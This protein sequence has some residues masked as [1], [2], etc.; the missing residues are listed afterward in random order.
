MTIIDKIFAEENRI[1]VLSIVIVLAITVRIAFGVYYGSQ[2]NFLHENDHWTWDNLA[3]NISKGNGYIINNVHPDKREVYSKEEIQKILQDEYFFSIVK[4]GKPTS[5]WEP[6]YAWFLALIY[7]IFGHSIIAALI[8]NAF[9]WGGV[10]Y[11]VYKIFVELNYPPIG[12]IAAIMTAFFPSFIFVSATLMTE[13]LF[14]FLMNLTIY[15]LLLGI[16]RLSWNIIVISG[17]VMGYTLLT[18]TNILFWLPIIVVFA[19]MTLKRK[20]ILFNLLWSVAIIA[21]ITPWI[22]RNHNV[23]GKY[24]FMPTKGP[25]VL[26]EWNIPIAS[27]TNKHKYDV[28]GMDHKTLKRIELKN[29]YMDSVGLQLEGETE[30]E[31]TASMKKL[32]MENIKNNPGY[33]VKNYATRFFQYLSPTMHTRSLIVRLGYLGI[34]T[35]IIILMILGMLR[36][37]KMDKR[38]W[39]FILFIVSYHFVIPFFHWHV[40]YKIVIEPYYLFFVSY[41]I[42]DIYFKNRMTT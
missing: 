15:F 14:I 40:R 28:D 3:E 25:R 4:Y 13:T 8:V 18:R 20:K 16:N 36:S 41:F 27:S 9:L 39:L 26:Y 33:I 29:T 19:F 5:F 1:T 42:W 34:Y 10:V 24:F 37:V 38:Y 23:H 31:R 32:A 2:P 6:G 11:L 30:I 21:M 35:P 22:I 7:K 17:L 12:L